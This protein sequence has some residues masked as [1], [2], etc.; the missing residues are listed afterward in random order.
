MEKLTRHSIQWFYN[1]LAKGECE[2]LD[3][4]EDLEDKI[5]FGKS[6]K[7]FAAKYDELAKDVVAFAN[8]KGGFL[9]VGIEDKTKEINPEFE[10]IDTKVFELIRQIQDR[11]V[12]SITIKPH[13]ISV[14]GKEILV[15]E[16]P[17]TT[18]LHRTS[19]SEYLIRSNDGNRPIET[20]EM[21]TVQ[22][23][24]GL[25]IYDQ[26]IWDLPLNSKEKDKQGNPIPGWQDINRKRDLWARIFQEK[27]D[28][29]QKV[30]WVFFLLLFQ[31]FLSFSQEVTLETDYLRVTFDEKG[32]ITT[33]QDRASGKDYLQQ[34][35]LD[36]ASLVRIRVGGEYWLPDAM[37]V[38]G[39]QIS[40]DYPIGKTALQLAVKS[41]PKYLS[42]ELIS[43]SSDVAIDL[44]VW[45]PFPTT[46]SEVIGESVGVVR[47]S[48]FALGIQA[49]NVKTLGG[50][51]TTEDDIEPAYDIFETGNLTDVEADWRRKKFY[52][53]QTAKPIDG[54]SILQAY[55]R[56]RQNDRII[57]NWGHTHYLAPAFSD[58]GI[59]GSKIAVFGCPPAKALEIIGE[60]ELAE[61]LP[62]PMIGGEWAKTAREATASY[63]IIGFTEDDLDQALALTKKAGLKYLYH[64]HPF[65]SWGHFPLIEKAFPD[66]WESMKRSVDRARQQGISL[67]VH[68]LSNFIQTND[69]YV[70]PIPDQ[71]LAKVGESSLVRDLAE[72]ADEIFI[73]SPLFFNQ[74]KNNA[75]KSVQIGDEII[76]YD[77]VSENQPWHLKGCIR[78]AFGTRASA[79]K[80]GTKIGKLMD[81]GYKVFL[82]DAALSEEIAITLANLFNE[83]GL[84]QISFDGLEGVWS[85]GMGQYARSLFTKTWYDHLNEDLRG[86]VINDASNPSHFN[87]HINTRYNWGEPWYAG[88][89]ES[90]TQYRLMNQDFYRRNLLPAML[91]WFSMNSQTSIEDTEWLLA[92]AAGFDAGFAFNLNLNQVAE[93]KASDAIFDAIKT[94]ETAR[95]AGAFSQDQKKRMEDIKNE[96]HL[97]PVGPS[98]WSLYQYKIERYVH[99]QKIRQPGEPVYSVFEFDNPYDE[100]ELMFIIDLKLGDGDRSSKIESIKV[101][102][103]NYA[104]L[105]IPVTMDRGQ[106]LKLGRA[107]QIELYEKNWDLVKTIPID[108]KIPLLKRGKNSIL[109]D[110]GFV[111]DGKASLRVE[112]KTESKPEKVVIRDK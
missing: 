51:P 53:G 48:D 107:G 66:N 98:E 100:Q 31:S 38:S 2:I 109:I 8:K 5:A 50:F 55:T 37:H 68:T 9:F 32:Q 110:A 17:F 76:R 103:N 28:I 20:F 18:Q 72:D 93:N 22:A 90:Q 91:G 77:E 25:I 11:T 95:M 42:F 27:F 43:V 44:I 92:R 10:Y 12:P 47:D 70:T 81:H 94:W 102:I 52:R 29:M 104:E 33:L 86:K 89:R 49:L 39:N 105:E 58:G 36:G 69:P 82:S 40:L 23:E 106:V 45:G 3:F 41:N 56:S 7:N 87:W 35:S 6:L 1:L 59:V 46:I 101:E 85:T 74:M 83:T 63:L 84:L 60:M 13:K 111:T 78:G 79:H 71:R 61:G 62:H 19:K 96:F 64:G 30:S 15:L 88:F 80:A 54:G 4:K 14:D 24:K 97:K 67:G 73:E 108:R 65:K 34:H 26:K 21:A 112:M 57:E 75:L 16:V 99:E